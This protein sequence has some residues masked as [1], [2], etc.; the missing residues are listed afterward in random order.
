MEIYVCK[1]CGAVVPEGQ[2]NQDGIRTCIMCVG[3]KGDGKNVIKLN[4]KFNEDLTIKCV[5]CKRE[6]KMTGKEPFLNIEKRTYYCGCR[7]WN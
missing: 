5:D 6:K 2:K 4:A 7:G 3:I 1:D